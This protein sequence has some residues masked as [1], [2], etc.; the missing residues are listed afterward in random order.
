MGTDAGQDGDA[1]FRQFVLDQRRSLLRTA[2]LLTSAVPLPEQPV[3]RGA[4]D[5]RR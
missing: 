3:T 1:A 2:Y 5:G 4:P